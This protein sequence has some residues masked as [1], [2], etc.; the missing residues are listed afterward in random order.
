M[1]RADI[2][3]NGILASLPPALVLSAIVLGHAAINAAFFPYDIDNLKLPSW[4]AAFIFGVVGVQPL[5]FA[6]WAAFGPGHFIIRLSFAVLS[7]ILV[8]VAKGLTQLN[9]PQPSGYHDR[10]DFIFFAV[11]SLETFVIATAIMRFLGFEWPR[12]I[13]RLSNDQSVR[14]SRS[15]YVVTHLVWLGIVGTAVFTVIRNIS[16][17]GST[18]GFSGY[19]L[20]GL[21]GGSLLTWTALIPVVSTCV[22]VIRE[23]VN[24][25]Q[26][27]KAG[28]TWALV[29]FVLYAVVF[30]L[31]P[32]E[33]S[34]V[35]L[36]V[37]ALFQIGA[38]AAGLVTALILRLAGYRLISGPSPNR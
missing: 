13:K 23:N 5:L 15:K 16:F 24:C 14:V 4:L 11:Y 30:A 32:N 25:R 12:R 18:G 8:T 35:A 34:F 38:A 17:S 28:V 19:H 37:I 10:I 26:M 3:P 20:M 9:V 21:T 7:L 1:T 36:V 29:T 22:P 6:I 33:T 31:D 27:K 2:P